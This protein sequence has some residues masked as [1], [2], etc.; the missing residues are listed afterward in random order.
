MSMSWCRPA[1]RH[2]GPRRCRD[3][4]GAG[5]WRLRTGRMH[6]GP[7]C[8]CR[9]PCPDGS[10]VLQPGGGV[11]R[12]QSHHVWRRGHQPAGRL[13]RHFEHVDEGHDQ[14]AEQPVLPGAEHLHVA[15]VREAIRVRLRRVRAVR[16]DDRLA[17][18]VA[19][20]LSRLQERRAGALHPADVRREAP[21]AHVG[22]RRGGRDLPERERTSARTSRLRCC[23]TARPSPRSAW[24]QAPTSPTSSSRA[25]R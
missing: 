14:H 15:A 13:H 21:R 19:G 6:D 17:C 10:G 18:E 3:G 23:P 22:R 12:R 11:V 4:F 5:V 7:R 25:T 8:R 2:A 16:P 20:A 9:Q 24:R 1:R